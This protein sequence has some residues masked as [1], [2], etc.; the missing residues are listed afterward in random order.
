MHDFAPL[1]QQYPSVIAAL[2]ETFTSHQFILALA[3]RH[4]ALYVAALCAYRD[5]DQGPFRVVHG[6]L[7]NRLNTFP[8]LVENTGS[9]VSSP[10]I[11]GNPGDAV[12]WR[13]R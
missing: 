11:F 10:D 12:Q 5:A 4:Q 3:W 13:K 6:I 7:A 2:P 9:T 1:L 8:A